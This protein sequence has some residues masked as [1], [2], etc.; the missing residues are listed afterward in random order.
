MGKVT[1]SNYPPFGVAVA[2]RDDALVKGKRRGGANGRSVSGGGGDGVV[3]V[4]FFFFLLFFVVVVVVVAVGSWLISNP[5]GPMRSSLGGDWTTGADKAG[6]QGK[7]GGREIQTKQ[8]DRVLYLIRQESG[9]LEWHRW[10]D[11]CTTMRATLNSYYQVPGGIP[12]V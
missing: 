11:V 4:F 7:L 5:T 12:P 10:A 3:V 2:S 6:G 9:G 8:P 1:R